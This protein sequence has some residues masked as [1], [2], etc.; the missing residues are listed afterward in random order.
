MPTS[1]LAVSPIHPC[2]KSVEPSTHASQSFLS[3]AS[4]PQAQSSVP[5][6][7]H[8]ARLSDE[9]L[10]ASASA[11]EDVHLPDV[12][13]GSSVSP[14]LATTRGSVN[15][16]STVQL[17]RCTVFSLGPR[18]AKRFRAASEP[19]IV[20][21]SCFVTDGASSAKRGAHKYK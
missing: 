14:I 2:S 17:S 20:V 11:C 18:L 15:T 10:S 19:L 9:R 12:S 4:V 1:A 7:G 3:V 21:L 6:A 8:V 13:L 16:G 5:A